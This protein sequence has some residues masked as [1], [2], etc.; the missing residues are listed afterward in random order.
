[1]KPLNPPGKIIELVVFLYAMTWEV[2][3]SRTRVACP[4]RDRPPQRYPDHTMPAKEGHLLGDARVFRKFWP[5]ERFAL[6]EVLRH[7]YIM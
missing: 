2:F 5:S 4:C 3:L 1:L 7:V 6:M